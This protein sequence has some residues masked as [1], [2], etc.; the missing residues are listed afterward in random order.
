MDR[1][2]KMDK[3]FKIKVNNKV[4][5]ILKYKRDSYYDDIKGEEVNTIELITKIPND[6]LDQKEVIINLDGE[7][8]IK[9]T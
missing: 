8:N 5:K 3:H 7:A 4:V 1:H 6:E 2:R 9:A